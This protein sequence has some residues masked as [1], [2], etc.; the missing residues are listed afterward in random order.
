MGFDESYYPDG[1]EINNVHTNSPAET[2]GLRTNDRIVAIN[3][4]RA[5]SGSAWDDLMSRTWRNSHPGDMVTLTLQR[6]GQSQP[7]VITPRFRARQGVGDTRTIAHTI[8]LQILQSYPLLFLFVGLAVLFLRAEDRDAWLLAL[9]FGTFIAA[10][11]MP[12]EFAAATPHLRSFLLAYRTLMGSLLTGMFYFFFAVFPARSPIERKVPWL[13][14]L[15][16][17]SGV[18]LSLEVTGTATPEHYLLSSR[19]CPTTSLRMLEESSFTGLFFWGSFPCCV[20]GSVPP[21][22][23]TCARSK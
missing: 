17:V 11:D 21:V 4:S 18:C 1:I 23:M 6:P 14:W 16:L 7:F 9:V 5:D 10:A 22:G 2:S 12:D 3:G 8:A 20:T 19:W 13:K 15:L